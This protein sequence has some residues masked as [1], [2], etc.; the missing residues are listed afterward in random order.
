MVCKTYSEVCGGSHLRNT[1][2]LEPEHPVCS[3]T[4]IEAESISPLRTDN[5]CEE[6]RG[7]RRTQMSH[8]MFGSYTRYG[9]GVIW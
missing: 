1:Q 6:R 4:G 3:Q 5:I 8:I 2:L 7:I 9:N